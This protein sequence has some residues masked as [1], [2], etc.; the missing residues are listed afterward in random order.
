MLGQRTWNTS[1]PLK[2]GLQGVPYQPAHVVH[3]ISPAW[4]GHGQLPDGPERNGFPAWSVH[5]CM[6]ESIPIS[7]G[8]VA[9]LCRVFVRGG[10][11]IIIWMGI[12]AC[13][14][15]LA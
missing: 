8:L 11:S 6:G 10:T 13:F 12:V 3:K 5:Q 9:N 2:R 15:E 4:Y 14:P 7:V 1:A